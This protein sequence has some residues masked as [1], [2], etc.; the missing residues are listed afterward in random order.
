MNWYLRELVRVI[1][2]L[3]GILTNSYIVIS[4]TASIIVEYCL[5]VWNDLTL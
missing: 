5:I 1:L 4:I 3:G 2:V